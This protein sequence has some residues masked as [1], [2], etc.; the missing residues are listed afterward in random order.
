MGTISYFAAG[1]FSCYIRHDPVIFQAFGRTLEAV[2]Y[3]H[4]ITHTVATFCS[5]FDHLHVAYNDQRDD[6]RVVLYAD[7]KR[8]MWG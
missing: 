6:M 1:V 5:Y 8:K 7:G 3:H 4:F 2:A